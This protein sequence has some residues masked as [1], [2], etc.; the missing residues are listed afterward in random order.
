MF[1]R[2]LVYF[3]FSFPIDELCETENGKG[4]RYHYLTAHAVNNQEALKAGV[5]KTGHYFRRGSC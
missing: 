3:S 5:R 4:Q 1:R 2:I